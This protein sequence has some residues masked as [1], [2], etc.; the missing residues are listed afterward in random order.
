MAVVDGIKE[1]GQHQHRHIPPS[2]TK[3]KKRSRSK[4]IARA[5]KRR[6]R[7]SLADG[8]T[9]HHD[10]CIS[11]QRLRISSLFE[12][13]IRTQSWLPERDIYSFFAALRRPLPVC[14]RIR[15]SRA[16]DEWDTICKIFHL[17]DAVHRV[18][19][20]AN[21]YQM[22]SYFL[23]NYPRLR[24]W[25]STSTLK[26]DIS[27]Q[28]YV[29]M[30]PVHLLNIQSQHKT[31]DLCA[32]PGSKTIQAMDALYASCDDKTTSSSTPPT[33][34][35]MANELDAKRA[36]VLAHRSRDTLQGRMVSMAVVTHNACKFPNVLAPCR[37]TQDPSDK[38][39][40]RI[41][42][43]VPCS[44]DGTL[45]K[46]FK[47]WKTWHPSYGI[48]LHSLQVR[49]AKR[50]IA[51]LKI[52]GYMTYSTC[53]FHPVENEA[54]V[55]ALLATRCVELVNAEELVG[56]SGMQGIRCRG[57]LD[58]WKVLNDDCEEVNV[59]A[60]PKEWPSS[61]WPPKK[62]GIAKSLSKCIRMVPQDNDTGGF[63]IAL[64]KKVKDFE[65]R[66]K[67]GNGSCTR[68]EPIVTTHASF[69]QLYPVSHDDDQAN[70]RCFTRSTREGTSLSNTKRFKIS[71]GLSEYLVGGPGSSKLNL[72]Y[73]GESL[74]EGRYKNT[75]T[76]ALGLD[77]HTEKLHWYISSCQCILSELLVNLLNS[78]RLV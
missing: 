7:A 55:A 22:P 17:H 13:Y 4:S 49:I 72:V 67:A 38:P 10:E 40:D 2:A 24:H 54:V 69:H 33:G 45:R 66:E 68:K 71:L 58:T 57:G 65:V 48:Q 21:A 12:T 59:D 5:R 18:P 61:L 15:S 75:V 11:H 32:S 77:L 46:D 27:R 70:F 20:D 28:E 62:V 51:L 36:Y 73:A 9:H 47:V 6:A 53:S 50:G 16:S 26:G 8:S 52:G 29:S 63:F 3:K 31:L 34:F 74:P 14:F 19:A 60:R 43:D 64:L 78:A 44:G 37:R 25:L 42:C 35:V 56:K 30:I 39:Y 76:Q 41:I 23:E 1:Q